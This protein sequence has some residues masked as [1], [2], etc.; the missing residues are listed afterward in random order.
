MQKKSNTI[1]Y[2]I[3]AVI[4]GAAGFLWYRNMKKK[5]EPLEPVKPLPPGPSPA[6]APTPTG[7]SAAPATKITELQNLMIKR[8]SQLNKES[9]YDKNAAFNP[10]GWGAKSTAALAYLQP[11]N[12]KSRGVPNSSNIDQWI[13]SIK[14]DVETAAK[15]E[16]TQQTAKKTR[17]DLISLEKA[18]KKHLDAPTGSKKIKLLTDVT[19]KPFQYD[20]ARGRYVLLDESPRK[21]TKGTIFKASEIW[22]R[23]NGTLGPGSGDKRYFIDASAFL[24][25]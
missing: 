22:T 11:S 21:F 16:A 25:V 18:L 8:F 13:A 10:P 3:G 17:T 2:L 4:L 14:K 20:Q 7:P 19:V 12:F 5:S 1:Y 6:P 24:A 15:E 23:G 9:E